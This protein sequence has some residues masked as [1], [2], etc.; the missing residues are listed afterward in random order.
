MNLTGIGHQKQADPDG[1]E[2][3]EMALRERPAKAT[4]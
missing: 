4:R 2:F 1:I 3:R